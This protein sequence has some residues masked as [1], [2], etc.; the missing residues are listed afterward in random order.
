MKSKATGAA[1]ILL[2]LVFLV[3]G[4]NGFLQFIPQPPMTGAAAQFMGG[5]AASGYFFPFMMAIQTLAGVA[6]LA[7][8]FVP[9]TLTVLAPIV[10]NIVLFHIFLAPMGLPLALL[11][12][13]LEVFLAWSHGGALRSVLLPRHEAAPSVRP[14]S[15]E[16]PAATAAE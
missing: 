8:R 13:G 14:S 6:L 16:A 12:L 2:G 4:L 7:G 10:V 11:V 5:L 1:R 9:L 3:F 15:L